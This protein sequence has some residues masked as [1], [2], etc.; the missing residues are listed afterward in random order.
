MT[1]RGARSW[2]ALAAGGDLPESK[3]QR[4]EQHLVS[5]KACREEYAAYR[6]SLDLAKSEVRRER[7]PAWREAEW[8][9]VMKAV[10]SQE[11]DNRPAGPSRVPGWTWAAAGAILIALVAGG[12]LVLR[13]TS[14]LPVIAGLIPSR[15]VVLPEPVPLPPSIRPQAKTP[16]AWTGARP[17][18]AHKST[19]PAPHL[20][21]RPAAP[22]TAQP[23]MAMTFV[24]QET[25]LTIHWVF[26]DSFNYKEDKK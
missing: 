18:L 11:P 26:N 24:S 1:H 25:G 12:F 10:L 6:E 23:V 2:M 9:N 7:T 16:Q 17:F 3:A 22:T 21:G 15:D 13:K 8:R 5:C 14:Q 19:S 4:L 20:T